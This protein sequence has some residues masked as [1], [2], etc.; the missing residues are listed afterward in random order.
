MI[1]LIPGSLALPRISIMP[2]STETAKVKI[3]SA[4]RDNV[5]TGG[6][7]IDIESKM[8][9]EACSYIFITP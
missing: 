2:Q 7:S 8:F 6:D 4:Y 1:A 5:V 3:K 9:E